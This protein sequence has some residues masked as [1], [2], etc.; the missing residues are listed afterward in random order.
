MALIWEPEQF[1]VEL[2]RREANVSIA[3]QLTGAPRASV[4]R[5]RQLDA[6]FSEQYRAALARGRA[7]RCQRIGRRARAVAAT[8]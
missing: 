3:C 1:L 5:L 2:E 8:T 7:R 6:E 4:Y